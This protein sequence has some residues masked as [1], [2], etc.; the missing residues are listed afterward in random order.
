MKSTLYTNCGRLFFL[1]QPKEL[2][3]HPRHKSRNITTRIK[4]CGWRREQR[5][6]GKKFHMQSFFILCILK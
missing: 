5:Y 6:T 4:L 1:S 3:F 2:V